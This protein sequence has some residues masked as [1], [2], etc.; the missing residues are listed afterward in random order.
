MRLSD[1]IG[2]LILLSIPSISPEPQNVKLLGVEA[3]GIWVES[4][5]AIN[6]ILESANLTSA[7]C[8]VAAFFPYGEVRFGV[9]FVDGLALNEKAMLE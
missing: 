7:P 8:S 1:Y 6:L 3:G 9:V 2:Q 5:H 4:Q